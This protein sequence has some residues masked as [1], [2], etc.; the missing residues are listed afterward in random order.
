MIILIIRLVLNLNNLF[1]KMKINLLTLCLCIA[2]QV[3]AQFVPGENFA[4]RGQEIAWMNAYRKNIK[5]KKFP[6]GVVG[7]P[8]DTE[9]FMSG[10]LFYKGKPSGTLPMRYDSYSDEFQILDEKD[11]IQAILKDKDVEIELNGEHYVLYDFV[12]KD[13]FNQFYFWQKFDGK[14]IDFLIRK[15]KWFQAGK[16][17]QN[18]FVQAFPSKFSDVREYFFKLEG[19]Q[20]TRISNS[21]SKFLK[22]LPEE[23]REDAKQF[24]DENKLSVRNP[25]DMLML[26]KHLDSK[27]F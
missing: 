26:I 4:S 11:S 7:S 9:I 8:Y 25:D 15:V 16:P 14:K 12:E 20:P 2:W 3:S 21:K 13:V 6:T 23:V 27:A 10:N 5:V 22:A 24:I 1:I 19:E 17:A 18:S